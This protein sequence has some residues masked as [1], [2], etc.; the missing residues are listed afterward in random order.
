M[1]EMN[2]IEF[3]CRFTASVNLAQHPLRYRQPRLQN[4]YFRL[5]RSLLL[6]ELPDEITQQRLDQYWLALKGATSDPVETMLAPTSRRFWIGESMLLN[7]LLL[8]AALISDR[9]EMLER[10]YERMCR[11]LDGINQ[12]QLEAV[13]QALL[14]PTLK[15]TFDPY[16]SDLL[17]QFRENQAH[18]QKKLFRV[19][20]AA[21]MSAGKSTFINAIMG[22]RLAR[23]SQEACTGNITYFFNK[24]F[25][26]HSVHLMTDQ[27]TLNASKEQ[28]NAVSWEKPTYVAAYFQSDFA[29]QYQTCLIDTPGVDSAVHKE[30]GGITKAFLKSGAY[31]KVVY[32]LSTGRLGTTAEFEFLD[33]MRENVSREKVIFVLNKIDTCGRDDNLSESIQGAQKD[34]IKIGFPS[35]VVYPISAYIAL[36]SKMKHNGCT[37]SRRELRTLDFFEQDFQ[38]PDNVALEYGNGG[39]TGEESEVVRQQKQCG[40]YGVEKQIFR[41]SFFDSVLGNHRR[42]MYR[43]EQSL[44]G[45]KPV[46]K[47]EEPPVA[48]K[49]PEVMHRQKAYRQTDTKQAKLG[50]NEAMGN[51]SD[52][53][54]VKIMYNPYTLDTRVEV[55]GEKLA[56]NSPLRERIAK[57]SHLQEWI[58]ELPELLVDQYNTT[59]FDIFFKGTEMDYYDVNEV[60][61]R[62]ERKGVLKEG[63]FRKDIFSSRLTWEPAKETKD[64]EVLIDQV[65][66]EIQQGPFPELKSE[67]LTSAYWNVKKGVFNVCVV[68]TMSAGKSTF[69]NALLGEKLMPSKQ[70]ACTAIITTIQDKQ[71]AC[72]GIW[73]ARILNRTG[74]ELESQNYLTYEDMQRFNEDRDNKGVAKVEVTGKIPF[75][76]SEDVSLVLVDT[77]G[78]NNARCKEHAEVQKSYLKNNANSV[79]LFIMDPAYEKSDDN[80]LLKEIA[81]SMKTGG[82][83]S[84]DRYFFV[85]NKLDQ[86]LTDDG[87][88]ETSLK[89]VCAYL[90]EEFDINNPNVYPAAAL[91]ALD[92]RL[93]KRG[94]FH[95]PRDHRRANNYIQD[96]NEDEILHFEQFAPLP[97]GIKEQIAESLKT[98]D[99]SQTALI[100]TGVVSIEAAIRLYV[101]KYAKTM[102]IRD[103]VDTFHKQLEQSGGSE[104]YISELMQSISGDQQEREQIRE[105]CRL[106]ER[107]VMDGENA[108]QFRGRVNTIVDAAIE[109]VKDAAKRKKKELQGTVRKDIKSLQ[110]GQ[111]TTQEARRIVDRWNSI[112]DR[113]SSRLQSEIQTLLEERLS[114]AANKLLE[115]YK[116]KLSSMVDTLDSGQQLVD[117]AVDPFRL[118]GVERHN[119]QIDALAYDVQVQHEVP[120]KNPNRVWYKPWAWF[121]KKIIYKTIFQTEQ[122]VDASELCHVYQTSVEEAFNEVVE[123]FTEHATEQLNKIRPKY[124][125]EFARL[126][127]IVTN[128][129]KDLQD[130]TASEQAIA[131]RIRQAQEKCDWLQ[132]IV[133]KVNRILEI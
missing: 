69:I 43:T 10:V 18:K 77:P 61:Q 73:K 14:D 98:S 19:A 20:V 38:M 4:D 55:E 93:L 122:R 83:Q 25:D 54:S 102:K 23:S 5:L 78:P 109:Q 72:P 53:T 128:K 35:P 31:D 104:K 85:L 34:L 107:N 91:P 86:R 62:A 12:K 118:I 68:A 71:D 126:D 99:E 32:I 101:Q 114:A 22:E 131:D 82:K 56:E 115:E 16:A 76:Q 24:A 123:K 103:L 88:L 84:R 15:P 29:N 111:L 48:R 87:S 127:G 96:F 110:G 41:H 2:R 27:V 9:P 70:E 59:R 8:D 125:A 124:A 94:R 116:E 74:E 17:L 58:E 121:Q 67:Q 40:L 129:L 28:L 60:L 66:R 120:M 108:K 30:H 63:D 33:W 65:F 113:F 49:E 7:Y 46:Y 133:E 13:Y 119:F 47:K 79:I 50:G 100:H 6:T 89:K 52:I 97:Q 37:L 112:S 26:D 132:Q 117:I 36:L 1:N 39:C 64:K 95:E 11:S 21:T 75:V 92:I 51:R 105:K 42:N 80:K 106:L 44:K 90:K 45:D 130:A 3:D 81:E 57:T